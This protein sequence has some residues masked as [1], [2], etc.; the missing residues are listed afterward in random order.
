RVAP[1]L[2]PQ[3]LVEALVPA[4]V[5]LEDHALLGPREQVGGGGQAHALD[6]AALRRRDARVEHVPLAVVA[7]DAAGPRGEGVEVVPL[8]GP[9]R[10]GQHLPAAQVAAHGVPD[11]RAVVA[12]VGV[13]ERLGCLEVEDVDVVPVV[14]EPEVPDPAVGQGERHAAAFFSCGEAGGRQPLR[15]E[16][17]RLWTNQRWKR[18]KTTRTGSTMT[19]PKSQ[20]SPLSEGG[21]PWNT[22]IASGSG[23]FCGWSIIMTGHR[24]EPHVVR[25]DKIA[26][27]A[28]TGLDIGT[29]MRR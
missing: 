10:V 17:A 8:A 25:K 7:H 1:R 3:A 2:R 27:V 12:Q 11:R 13:T 14:G 21:W 26:T 29:T 6:R 22:A 18:R 16:D 20:I 4:G 9:E 23:R 24:K 5:G 19:T 15:P 28:K